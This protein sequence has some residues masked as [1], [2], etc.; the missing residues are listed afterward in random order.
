MEYYG[1]SGKYEEVREWYDGY[2]LERRK[3]IVP[4]DVLNYVKD[5]LFDP[6]AEPKL[7]WANSSSNSIVKSILEQST[8]R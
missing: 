1:I 6:D 5:H 4:W 8:A 3:C 2:R 7:Y